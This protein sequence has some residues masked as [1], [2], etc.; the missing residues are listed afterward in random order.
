M[1]QLL[2]LFKTLHLLLLGLFPYLK[3]FL[4]INTAYPR[5]ILPLIRVKL[6][7]IEA[8][9]V[10]QIE[11]VHSIQVFTEEV[12]DHIE[13]LEALL[14]YLLT[15]LIVFLRLFFIKFQIIVVFFNNFNVI[16]CL[17]N[18]WV[19]RLNFKHRK[20]GVSKFFVVF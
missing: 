17:K 14:S 18:R 20:E 19:Y 6:R 13:R 5:A 8:R 9:G 12:V 11:I 15:L 4:L 3:Y 16:V 2:K 7:Q 1:K 10:H